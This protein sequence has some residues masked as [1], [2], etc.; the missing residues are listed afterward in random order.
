MDQQTKDLI[1]EAQ[2]ML[3]TLTAKNHIVYQVTTHIDRLQRTGEG[4]EV[5]EH[6]LSCIKSNKAKHVRQKYIKRVF[7][8]DNVILDANLIKYEFYSRCNRHNEWTKVKRI[9]KNIL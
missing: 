1:S 7:Y 6:F 3:S 9:A 2:T 4:K 8:W 5:V